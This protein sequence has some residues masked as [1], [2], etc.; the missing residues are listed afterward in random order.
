[1]SREISGSFSCHEFELISKNFNTSDE[2]D[3]AVDQPLYADEANRHAW[4]TAVKDS[5]FAVYDKGCELKKSI[6]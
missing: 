3:E 2:K 1:M 6:V 5:E 4:T